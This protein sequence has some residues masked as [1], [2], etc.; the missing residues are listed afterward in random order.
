MSGLVLMCSTGISRNL[1]RNA[2][3][4]NTFKIELT[5]QHVGDALMEIEET[6]QRLTTRFS[7]ENPNYCL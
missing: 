6:R 3:I 4:T 5:A 2:D 1:C 7:C